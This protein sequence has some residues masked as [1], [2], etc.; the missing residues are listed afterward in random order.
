[1]SDKENLTKQIIIR[2]SPAMHQEL[3]AIAN[4]EERPLT[5]LVRMLVGAQL[6]QR[7]EAERAPQ[8]NMSE[9]WKRIIE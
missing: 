7:R 9:A 3:T 4:R 1:M 6:K 8:P 5:N 2:V